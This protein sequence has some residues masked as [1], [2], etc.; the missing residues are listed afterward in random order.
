[1][2]YGK[3]PARGAY[4]KYLPGGAFDLYGFWEINENINLA[5]GSYV[6]YKPWLVVYTANIRPE[7]EVIEVCGHIALAEYDIFYSTHVNY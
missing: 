3:L 5:R 4:T 2:I 6:I 1:M 7:T